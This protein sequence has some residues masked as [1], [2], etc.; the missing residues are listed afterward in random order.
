MS[1]LRINLKLLLLIAVLSAVDLKVIMLMSDS[2]EDCSDGGA[3]YID[4]SGLEYDYVND[5]TYYL[6][7]KSFNALCRFRDNISP[8]QQAN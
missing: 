8:Y 2:F 1:F 5:T 4:Y 3:K 6:S 7:G